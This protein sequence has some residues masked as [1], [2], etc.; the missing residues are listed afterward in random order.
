M[1]GLALAIVAFIALTVRASFR[2]VTDRYVKQWGVD[3]ATVAAIRA[4]R[5]GRL[6]GWLTWIAVRPSLSLWR[7]FF[8]FA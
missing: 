4:R 2:Q 8:R 5:G 7:V 1:A 6:N 3:A